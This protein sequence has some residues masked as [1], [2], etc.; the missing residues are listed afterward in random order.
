MTDAIVAEAR[1]PFARTEQGGR[2]RWRIRAGDRAAAALGAGAYPPLIRHLL[3]GRG[4]RTDDAAMRFLDEVAGPSVAVSHDPFLLP[5]MDHAVARLLAA[6]RGGERI[7]AYGD[8][9]VDG[10]TSCALLYQGLSALGFD[11]VTYI[12][13]RFREGYG[14]NNGALAELAALGITLVITADCGTSNVA[15]VAYAKERGVD[16]IVADHHTVPPE[17][18]DAVAVVNPKRP[19]TPY[20]YTELAACGV[21][22]KLLHA[23]YEALGR[24]FPYEDYIDLVALGTVVDMAPLTGENREIVRSGLRVLART[25][26]PGLLALMRVSGAEP[27]TLD[28]RD[29]GFGLGPRLNA[30]GRLTHARQ[31]LEL[32]LEQDEV[33]AGQLAAAL[34]ELNAERRRQ[35]DEALA[36]ARELAGRRSD[37]PP[38]TFVGHESI[39]AGIVGL[40][41]GRLAEERHRPAIVYQEMGAECRASA[42]SIPA[43]DIVAALREHAP[44]MERFGGHRQAAG[45]TV[46]TAR[47]DQLREAL[48]RTAAERLT[49][50]DLEPSLDIDAAIPLSRLLGDEVR[51]I[52]RFGP[53]GIGNPEL[54]L[55]SRGVRVAD[56]KTVGE[57]GEHLRL[58]LRDGAV[59]W[60]AIAFRQGE[61]PI[62]RGMLADVVYTLTPDRFAGGAMLQMQVKDIAPASGTPAALP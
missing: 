55:L 61:A 33:R 18:P 50:A 31:A 2:Y 16:V 37:N 41:A 1:G 25:K 51:W 43:F 27:Q 57:G 30:A 54:T 4:I 5:D 44:L 60:P 10:V 49:A 28:A 62:E 29:L 52:S 56:C 59:M 34:H 6:L 26:R 42:R 53:F 20:P 24:T 58:T 36:L 8:F 48:E 13:D 14:L 9:D 35:T 46:A 23:T 32:V 21:V 12:P 39:S 22:Y 19:D 3:W 15:E 17:L 40:V 47:R 38:I 11:I 45:F 7:A